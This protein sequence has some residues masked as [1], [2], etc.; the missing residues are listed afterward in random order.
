MTMYKQ[1]YLQKILDEALGI[2]EWVITILPNTRIGSKFRLFYWKQKVG[3]PTLK[4]IGK[5][6]HILNRSGMDLGDNFILGDFS[7]L[8]IADSSPIFIGDNVGIARGTF[9]RSANHAIDDISIPILEQGH[10]SKKID[11]RGKIYSIIIE[12]NVWV[13]ANSIILTGAHIGACSV[14]SAGS[15]V[16]SEVPPYSI[17]VGNP[18]RVMANRLKLAKLKDMGGEVING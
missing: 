2:F 6:A 3:N 5:H 14:I 11:F 1:S 16:S 9:L 13:G 4:Y 18:G 15:V 8:Q 7:E 17:V 10:T 12:D